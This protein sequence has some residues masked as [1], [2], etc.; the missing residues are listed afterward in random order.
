MS[1]AAAC[2]I[3]IDALFFCETFDVAVL[4]EVLFHVNTGIYRRRG[5][6]LVGFVLDVVVE[7]H[8]HLSV[9]EDFLSSYSHESDA[10]A[11]ATDKERYF[12]ATGQARISA[13]HRE[14]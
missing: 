14:L 5:G 13:I 11:I 3:E 1:Y 2:G 9:I 7:S 10:L 4:F 6:Y 12:N 8:Y